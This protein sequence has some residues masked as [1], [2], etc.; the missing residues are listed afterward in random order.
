MSFLVKST[1][2]LFL[3]YP[4]YVRSEK[5]VR[6][7]D[8][9]TFI[10]NNGEK[11]RMIGINAPEESDLYGP[12]AAYYLQKLII[13]QDITLIPDRIGRERD[14]YG[15][16]LRYAILNS[17]DINKKMIEDG[18]AFAY[19]KYKFERKN[20]YR[21]AQIKAQ[22][23]GFGMWSNANHNGHSNKD[24]SNIE[25]PLSNKLMVLIAAILV[26]VGIAIKTMISK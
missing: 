4:N 22:N 25:K 10:L 14:R 3:I 24:I 21:N 17:V 23:S 12:E 9:D 6:V 13:N 26:L 20:D 18:Y 2:L 8:G 19:L 11:V 15:R 16:L 5:V 7:I 1:I